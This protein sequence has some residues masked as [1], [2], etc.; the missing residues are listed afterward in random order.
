MKTHKFFLFFISILTMLLSS[1]GVSNAVETTITDSSRNFRPQR[2]S[3]RDLSTEAGFDSSTLRNMEKMIEQG[4]LLSDP[5]LLIEAAL[6]LGFYEQ[7]WQIKSS[8]IDAQEI[9]EEAESIAFKKQNTEQLEKIRNAYQE[10]SM[11][12]YNLEKAEEI[13]NCIDSINSR[14]NNN[15]RQASIVVY[16][17]TRQNR[18]YVYVDNVFLG[19]VEPGRTERF[20]GIAAGRVSIS[21]HDNTRFQWGPRRIFLGNRDVFN[22]RLYSTSNI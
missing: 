2:Y 10:R 18:I 15:A 3:L 9:L 16:N 7:Q 12:F 13:N 22:W 6:L 21:A 11:S 4:F 1:N 14:S 17:F 5:E 8:Q 20:D 19:I